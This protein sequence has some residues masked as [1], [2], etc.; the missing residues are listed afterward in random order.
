MFSVTNH[1]G[2]AN[3]NQNEI[4]PHI[5][6]NGYYQGKKSGG[7][8]VE[9]LNPCAELVGVQNGIVSVK[10]SMAIPQKM[11]SRITV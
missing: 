6:Q 7:K 9:K 2:N 10:N 8:D 5:H 3:Q 1:Q 11:K 4:P